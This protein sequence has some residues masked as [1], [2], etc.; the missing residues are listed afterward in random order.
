M[1]AVRRASRA[2]SAASTA[3]ERCTTT[4]M[5]NSVASHTSPGATRTSRS[6]LSRAKANSTITIAANGSTWLMRTRLR[7]SIRRS[8]AA[9]RR[10]TLK[11]GHGASPS[12]SPAR[13]R[14]CPPSH[15]DDP[16]RQRARPGPARGWRRSSS[17][18]PP[19][20]HAGRCR[21]RRGRLRRGLRG[22][23]RAATVRRGGRSGTREPYDAAGRPRACEPARH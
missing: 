20:L 21:A 6:S 17:P 3:N 9:T 5:L 13:S 10:V 12:P 16:C 4:S 11:R 8:F 23:R 18:L 7:N 22:A 2:P 14:I 1:P 19:S 15:L